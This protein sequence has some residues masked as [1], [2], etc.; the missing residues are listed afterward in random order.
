M[1]ERRQRESATLV[2]CRAS[3]AKIRPEVFPRPSWGGASSRPRRSA[4][5]GTVRVSPL[6]PRTPVPSLTTRERVRAVPETG[7]SSVSVPRAEARQPRGVGGPGGG[8]QPLPRPSRAPQPRAGACVSPRRPLPRG[9]ARG[10][11]GARARPRSGLL[12]AAGAGAG[13]G[14]GLRT[15]QTRRAG[16]ELRAPPA[17]DRPPSPAASGRAVRPGHTEPAG[18]GEMSGDPAAAPQ[19]GEGR[20]AVP[21]RTGAPVK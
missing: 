5:G 21:S 3:A 14:A 12:E 1:P 13:A 4:L 7:A 2:L 15:C 20:A 6:G 11:S 8:A 9:L 16:L 17:R 18:G 10:R 19:D